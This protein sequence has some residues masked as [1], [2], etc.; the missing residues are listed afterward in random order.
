MLLFGWN[1]FRVRATPG[2]MQDLHDEVLEQARARVGQ[3]L[4]G[5]YRVDRLIGFGGMAS[6]YAGVHLRNA[7]RVALKVLHREFAIQAD[8]R[9]RFLREGYAANIVDHPG[10]VRVLDDDKAEDG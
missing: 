2:A 6:V 9:A 4:C 5:K 1:L 3:V 8:L 7:N 10:T